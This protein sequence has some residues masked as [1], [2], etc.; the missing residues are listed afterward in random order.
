MPSTLT[1]GNPLEIHQSHFCAQEYE[2]TPKFVDSLK[3]S[4]STVNGDTATAIVES[5]YGSKTTFHFSMVKGKWLISG[6]CVYQ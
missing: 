1:L 2:Y 6:Y 4:K 3:F 5:P